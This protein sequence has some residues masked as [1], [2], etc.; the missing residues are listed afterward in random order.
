MPADR[1]TVFIHLPIVDVVTGLCGLTKDKNSLC[2]YLLSCSRKGSAR[3][4]YSL[5][6]ITGQ[7]AST[8]AANIHTSTDFP[9]LEIF[10]RSVTRNLIDPE[11]SVLFLKSKA[12]IVCSLC[13]AANAQSITV[14]SVNHFKLSSVKGVRVTWVLADE[15]YIYL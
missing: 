8:S 15:G 9:G 12:H 11:V 5:K 7:M 13:A 10:N 6:V 4:I 3:E 2:W 1:I 14:L